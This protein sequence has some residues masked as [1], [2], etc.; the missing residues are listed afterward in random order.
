M[1]IRGGTGIDLFEST[2]RLQLVPGFY[3]VVREESSTTPLKHEEVELTD[4]GNGPLMTQPIGRR[5]EH[6]EFLSSPKMKSLG[7]TTW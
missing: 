2:I 4:G 1:F 6:G 7:L 5:T 3:L